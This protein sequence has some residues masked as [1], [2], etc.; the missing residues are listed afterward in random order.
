VRGETAGVPERGGAGAELVA[1]TGSTAAP[2]PRRRVLATAGAE[3]TA[4]EGAPIAGPAAQPST[5]SSVAFAARPAVEVR[6]RSFAAG[7]AAPAP[8]PARLGGVGE[9]RVGG[10]GVTLQPAGANGGRGGFG[11]IWPPDGS[12]L[13]AALVIALAVIVFARRRRALLDGLRVA[14]AT[15]FARVR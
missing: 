3:G 11:A 15:G 13:A 6:G 10:R 8:P 1:Q 7:A 12:R 9:H 2:V 14:L 4:A 5:A